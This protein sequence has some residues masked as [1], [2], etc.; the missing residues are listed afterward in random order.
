M[1]VHGVG[2]I[3]QVRGKG[4]AKVPNSWQLVLTLDDDP[5]T[6][7]RRRVFRPFRG[8]KTAARKAL[9]TFRH[10]V[11]NGLKVDA[12]KMTFGKY[13]RS[14]LEGRKA[15]GRL[16]PATICRDDYL[17]RH[18][19]NN[20]DEAKLQD[21]DAATV[22]S[23]YAKLAKEGKG[24]QTAAKVAVMLNQILR[25]AV[26]DDLLLRNPCDRV[27][28]PKAPKAQA[29]GSLDKQGIARLM[30]ALKDA[31]TAIDDHPR[32]EQCKRASS[33]SHITAVRLA[34]SAGLRRGEVLG[35]SWGDVD[36]VGGILHV[37]KS[38]CN[39]SGKLKTP[40]TASSIRDVAL[41]VR[42]L[43]ELGRWKAVQAEYLITFGIA[44]RAETPVI[45][46]EIGDR[47]EGNNMGRWWRDFCVK[48]GFGEYRDDDGNQIPSPRYN[49]H[50]KQVDAEGRC[51]SRMNKKQKPNKHYRGLRF[52]DL[53][54]SHATML[55]SSGLNPKAV[56]SRLG[57]S[58]VGITLD[59]YAHA[60]RE[61]DEKAAAIMGE[62]MAGQVEPLGQVVSL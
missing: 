29:G 55:I 13:A 39:T 43:A 62:V 28:A 30:A 54:H 26:N 9:E 48:H 5:V 27:D 44:Q 45:S 31:E 1:K 49:E 11:E 3:Q 58:S 18:L 51:F 36:L 34:L 24:T 38:L 17:I 42:M 8:N 4:G 61:D 20:L 33:L 10:E 47:M 52:H 32:T 35:L 41:D 46:N 23:L 19:L 14:W 22:R 25:Q 56:S 53:R 37:R 60:Q 16:A 57:H 12:D 50:G 7:Q 21:I 59:L 15:S 40:K 2:Y 6:K